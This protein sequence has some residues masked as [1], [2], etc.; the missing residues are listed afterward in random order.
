MKKILSLLL[1]TLVSIASSL[2]Q[3]AKEILDKASDTFL[4]SGGVIAT[5]TLNAKE[6]NNNRTYIQDGAAYMKG[7]KF[8]IEI[9]DAIT[10]F[11]GKTQWTYIKDNEEVN[12]SAPTGTE[13][14]SISPSILFSIYKTGYNLKYN[15]EK[16]VNGKIVDEIEMTAQSKKNELKKI[17]VQIDKTDNTFAKITL[18]DSNGMENT[19]IINSYKVD[20]TLTDD[21]FVFNSKEY[22][23]VDIIDLR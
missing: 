12:V 23:D 14:Q 13:L 1:F 4:K 6:M 19:L 20:K 17:V 10:W 3:N 9:A 8:K 21:F 15:G 2:G 18:Y 5:F 7:D 22:P 11:D 16:K